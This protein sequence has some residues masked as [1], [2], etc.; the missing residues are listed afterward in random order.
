MTRI[1]LVARDPPWLCGFTRRLTG[2]RAAAGSA[3]GPP[4]DNGSVAPLV[5][6][7]ETQRPLPAL[8]GIRQ[9]GLAAGGGPQGLLHLGATVE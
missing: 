3:V 2:F 9:R 7:P 1:P 5:R 8:L 4:P 6:D